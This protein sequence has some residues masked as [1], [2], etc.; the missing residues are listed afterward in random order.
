MERGT[1]VTDGKREREGGRERERESRDSRL[2]ADDDFTPKNG[3]FAKLNLPFCDSI[4]Y[5]LFKR[6]LFHLFLLILL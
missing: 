1:I 4:L 3:L 5:F 2:D 6:I